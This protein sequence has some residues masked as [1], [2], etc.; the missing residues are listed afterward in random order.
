M[1]FGILS[2]SGCIKY[3]IS[4]LKNIKSENRQRELIV[5]ENGSIL[6]YFI[7]KYLLL[8]SL[9]V[10]I[11]EVRELQARCGFCYTSLSRVTYYRHDSYPICIN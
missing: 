2:S 11:T 9:S 3:G 8:L 7:F 10:Q 4:A 6:F 5:E 1:M